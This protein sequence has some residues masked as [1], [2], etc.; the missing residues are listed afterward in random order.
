ML[1][2]L[3]EPSAATGHSRDRRAERVSSRADASDEDR[4][5]TC[6]D[7]LAEVPALLQRDV[8]VDRLVERI[9]RADVRRELPGCDEVEE[10]GDV[11]VHP[12]VAA[13]NGQ[14]AA[15]DVPD[16]GGRIEARERAVRRPRR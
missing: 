12:A 1:P 16:V 5:P 7:D 13:L 2:S 6:H 15:E 4:R 10:L 9:G 11:L 14:L 8:R 3:E